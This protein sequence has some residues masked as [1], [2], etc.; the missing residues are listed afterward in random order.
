MCGVG[1]TNK[2]FSSSVGVLDNHLRLSFVGAGFDSPAERTGGCGV[3]WSIIPA[4][5]AGD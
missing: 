5:E 2:L 3:T 1:G 4:L